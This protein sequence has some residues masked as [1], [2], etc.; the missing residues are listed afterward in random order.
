[1]GLELGLL[2]LVSTTEIEELPGRK[3]SGSGLEKREYSCRDPPCSSCNTPLSAK[4]GTN[5]ANK[6]RSLGRFS[7]LVD[8]GHG[9]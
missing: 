9:V 1:V 2:S 3:S 6:W 8:S 5:F 4:A 7:S